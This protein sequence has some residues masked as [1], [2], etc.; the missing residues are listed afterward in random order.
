MSF[1]FKRLPFAIKLILVALIPL[2]FA[3]YLTFQFY[4]EKSQRLQLIKSYK[5][6]IQLSADLSGLID[7]LQ[8]E[9]KFSFDYAVSNAPLQQLLTQRP[10]TDYYIKRLKESNDLS[11]SHFPDYTNLNKLGE[12]R[13]RIDTSKISPD[14]VMHYYSNMIFRLN[15]LNAIPISQNSYLESLYKELAAQKIL[16]EMVTYLGIIRSNIYNVLYTKKYMIETLIGTIGTHDVYNSY[17]TEFLLKASPSISNTYKTIKINTALNATTAY[18]DSLFRRFKFDSTYTPQQWW[19]VSN[20]GAEELRKLQKQIWQNINTELEN[21]QLKEKTS[22]ERTLLFLLIIF[23]FV[24]GVVT[25]TIFV[26]SRSLGD[27]KI[28]AQKIS[29]GFTDVSV[30]HSA[31]DVI[32]DLADCIAEIDKNNK[33]LAEATT[34]IGK[35]NFAVIVRPRSED[36]S[37]GNA[38]VQMKNELQKYK[39]QMELLVHQRTEELNRSNEDLQQFAHVASHDLKEPLRKIKTFSGRLLDE[40]QDVLNE[41]G[42]LYLDKIQ[43]ASDRMA[44]MVEGVL[45]YSI[46]NAYNQPFESIDL[47]AIIEGIKSDL[48][49]LIIQKDAVIK[50]EK[51][52]VMCG[53]PVLIHQLF[54]N[55]VN[56]SLKFSKESTPANISIRSC[57][58]SSQDLLQLQYAHSFSGYTKIEVS[59]NGIGFDSTMSAQMFTAFTRLNARDKYEGTGLGLALC[60]KIV[61]RHNGVIYAQGEEDHGSTFSIILPKDN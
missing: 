28:A 17:E 5:D 14:V 42:K 51:L 7:N 10:K 43:N 59:D 34:A 45:N 6:R 19:T 1:R 29:K 60:K 48:E 55:L 32:G 24:V 27:L 30:E 33:Q 11:I 25:Y 54:Y 22:Q 41:K 4:Q 23:L 9:R 2:L 50:H 16:T 13:S 3:I 8:E 35:G 53:I 26:I 52:P 56:N 12:I 57:K 15:T 58:P 20:N 38:I 21:I 31:N 46:V 39:E 18:I 40:Q 36:D 61:E 37:L 47:N 49:I 44:K